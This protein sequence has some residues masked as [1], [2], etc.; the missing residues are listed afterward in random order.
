MSD[1]DWADIEE[2]RRR[3]WLQQHQNVS[4]DFI[5]ETQKLITQR[6][7]DENAARALRSL[8]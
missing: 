5:T 3:L 2:L 1:A 8:I 7:A 6:V 4:E